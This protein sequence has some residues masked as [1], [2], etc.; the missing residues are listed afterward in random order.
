MSKQ[1]ITIYGVKSLYRVSLGFHGD[2][3]GA[4]KSNLKQSWKSF[5]EGSFV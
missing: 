4:H 1:A 3:W 2:I 5:K